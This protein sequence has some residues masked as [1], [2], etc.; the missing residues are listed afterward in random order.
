M[1]IHSPDNGNEDDLL[2]PAIAA[3]KLS[4]DTLGSK[5][6]DA[7][8]QS[9]N[10]NEW[11]QVVSLWRSFMD[12]VAEL[13]DSS[14]QG[15]ETPQQK[16]ILRSLEGLGS[17]FDKIAREEQAAG[18]KIRWNSMSMSGLAMQLFS[19]RVPGYS[20]GLGPRVDD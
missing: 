13:F 10:L 2:P 18:K 19:E 11:T 16:A 3:E 4:L 17:R 8:R 5:Y 9:L 20:V 15:L 6:D 14:I 1:S 7:I 12:K